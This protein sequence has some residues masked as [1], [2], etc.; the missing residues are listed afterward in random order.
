MTREAKLIALL[1]ADKDELLAAC[2]KLLAILDLQPE[3]KLGGWNWP[4]IADE[5]RVIVAKHTKP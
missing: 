3:P 4:A 2:Q 5:I 1:E